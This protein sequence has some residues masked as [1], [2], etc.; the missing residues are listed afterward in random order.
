MSMVLNAGSECISNVYQLLFTFR[1]LM[2][3]LY[4]DLHKSRVRSNVENKKTLKEKR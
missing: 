2:E 3:K 1:N 4:S